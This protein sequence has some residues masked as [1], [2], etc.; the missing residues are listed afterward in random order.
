MKRPTLHHNKS[1][2]TSNAD[3]EY[4]LKLED[5]TKVFGSFTALNKVSFEVKK[6]ERIGLLGGNGAGKTT[7]S[8]IIMGINPLSSGTITYGFDFDHI[9]QEK[10]GMQFQDNIYPSGLR[11]KD[12]IQFAMKVNDVKMPKNELNELLDT[13]QMREF[14]N[15]NTRSLSGG[16]R[17]KLNILLA[18]INRPKLVIL[19][20]ISTGLDIA[21]RH[22]I[23]NFTR[24]LLEKQGISAI[25]ISHHMGEIEALCEKVVV[26]DRGNVDDILSI[27]DIVKNHGSLGEYMERK[28]IEGNERAKQQL[29]TEEEGIEY[30]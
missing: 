6:G 30:E 9:P 22:E 27:E 12:I 2:I 4:I 7:L 3:S 17:Q 8:E 10:M 19:D 29:D 26:L 28:I 11:I 20:E 23:I 5:V 16:Q 25:V 24:D 15:R 21:A 14:Y 18:I 1:V 13:F